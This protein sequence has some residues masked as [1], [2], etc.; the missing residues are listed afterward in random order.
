[1]R[2]IEQDNKT[3][4]RSSI[5]LFYA[6]SAVFLAREWSQF[7]FGFLTIPPYLKITPN[8]FIEPNKIQ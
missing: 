8:L 7:D 6:C 5:L 1:M 3:I 2:Y 4:K